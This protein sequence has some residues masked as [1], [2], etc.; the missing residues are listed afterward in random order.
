M[1][2][3]VANDANDANANDN[4]RLEE[5]L[6]F[7]DQNNPE[8]FDIPSLKCLRCN[9]II[10]VGGRDY[11]REHCSHNIGFCIRYYNFNAVCN[12]QD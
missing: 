6:L 2:L 8:F 11:E 10:A 7:N 9:R 12:N 4:I 3:A 1:N 5:P